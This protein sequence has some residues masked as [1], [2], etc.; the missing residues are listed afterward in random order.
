MDNG[1]QTLRKDGMNLRTKQ[2]CF[3]V[4][5]SWNLNKARCHGICSRTFH[6]IGAL[7]WLTRGTISDTAYG[8]SKEKSD[9]LLCSNTALRWH[10]F[11]QTRW[12][13][14]AIT[15]CLR[16]TAEAPVYTLLLSAAG[17]CLWSQSWSPADAPCR[18]GTQCHWSWK[19][20]TT[21][22]FLNYSD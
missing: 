16:G 15:Y 18:R 17:Q 7:C 4:S 9:W 21:T 2:R 5:F 20:V 22:R 13:R 8:F 1:M 12:G 6:P 14:V 11:A 3:V 19:T 10:R